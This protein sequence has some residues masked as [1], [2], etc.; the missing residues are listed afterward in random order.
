MAGP[1]R[2]DL[3]AVVKAQTLIADGRPLPTPCGQNLPVS[4]RPM[5]DGSS[6]G[7]GGFH[8]EE[9]AARCA[10]RSET[11][12]RRHSRF[13]SNQSATNMKSR[14]VGKPSSPLTM[15]TL[16][17]LMCTQT[18]GCRYGTREIAGRLLKYSTSTNFRFRRR[19]RKRNVEQQLSTPCGQN[20]LVSTR[21]VAV[22]HSWAYLSPMRELAAFVPVILLPSFGAAAECP[23]AFTPNDV[24]LLRPTMPSLPDR[25]RDPFPEA[26]ALVTCRIAVG[27]HLNGC[28][29]NLADERGAALVAYV[30]R[31]RIVSSVSRGCPLRGRQFSAK[32]ELRYGG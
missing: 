3:P 19:I 24:K 15:D 7:Y 12:L 20:L 29:S 25:D 18:I 14:P 17:P 11:I 16:I 9:D 30:T 6:E 8:T 32:F 21:P 5:A 31:W 10:C 28:S 4:T 1:F 22:V 26:D 27:G 13:L 2:L 23:R